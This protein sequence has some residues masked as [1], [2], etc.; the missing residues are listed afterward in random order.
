MNFQHIWENSPLFLKMR[1]PDLYEG[2]CGVCEY[3]R[4]CGGCRA[5]AFSST[6][7]IMSEEPYC[8]YEPAGRKVK[9]DART[10]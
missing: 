9:S 7:N 8:I 4:V 1:N 3:I 2:K 10:E 6:G 5:R